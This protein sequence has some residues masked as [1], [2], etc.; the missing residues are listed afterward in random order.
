MLHLIKQI[1]VFSPKLHAYPKKGLKK[2]CREERQAEEQGA[3]SVAARPHGQVAPSPCCPHAARVTRVTAMLKRETSVSEAEERTAGR[4]GR[5]AKPR[6]RMHIQNEDPSP[7][8]SR[9]LSATCSTN[10]LL[11][12][13]GKTVKK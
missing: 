2:F 11:K 10:R 1:S 9:A 7:P 3:V 13:E 5:G 12:N 4:E 6:S 8:T